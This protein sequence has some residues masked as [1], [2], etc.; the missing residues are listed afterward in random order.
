MLYQKEAAW[1][2]IDRSVGLAPDEDASRVITV[3]RAHAEPLITR[4]SVLL[5]NL[6]LKRA[7]EQGSSDDKRSAEL[8]LQKSSARQGRWVWVRLWLT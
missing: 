6:D 3:L 5:V 8:V 1:D 2:G 7:I 4:E